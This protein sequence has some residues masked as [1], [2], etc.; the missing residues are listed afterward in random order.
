VALSKDSPSGRGIADAAARGSYIQRC[1]RRASGIQDTYS[2]ILNF[3]YLEE[4][5]ESMCGL[6]H[7]C[8]QLCP[9]MEVDP[10]HGKNK[11]D[12]IGHKQH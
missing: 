7:L 9:S 1:V 10:N 6:V 2:S 11:Q 5:G 12:F 4:G 3:D 8:S